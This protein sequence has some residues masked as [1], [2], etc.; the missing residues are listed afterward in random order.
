M[1]PT[2]VPPIILN[3]KWLSH[4]NDLHASFCSNFD[5]YLFSKVQM[6]CHL[7]HLFKIK[8]Q[9]HEK[10]HQ[11]QKIKLSIFQFYALSWRPRVNMTTGY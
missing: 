7:R 10:G 8:G 5:P 9:G 6:S 3:G 2:W 11:V 4:R 1:A